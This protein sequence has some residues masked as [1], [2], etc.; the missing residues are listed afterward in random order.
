MATWYIIL[1][2]LLLLFVFENNGIPYLLCCIFCM[3]INGIPSCCMVYFCMK[4]NGIQCC[5]VVYYSMAQQRMM[6]QVWHRP[7]SD[8]ILGAV[9]SNELLIR[10]H[11]AHRPHHAHRAH[12]AH[13]HHAHRT[14]LRQ[15]AQHCGR[16]PLIQERVGG[17]RGGVYDHKQGP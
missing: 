8:S 4:I 11:H 5:C 3:K 16:F 2:L 6:L 1:L 10:A 17:E 13:Q 14:K 15:A 7:R 9:D 12:C